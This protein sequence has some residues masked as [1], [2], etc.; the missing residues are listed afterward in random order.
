M[1]KKICVNCGEVIA[2]GSDYCEKCGYNPSLS[3]DTSEKIAPP[4]PERTLKNK[5]KIPGKGFGITSLVT[6]IIALFYG[7]YFVYGMSKIQLV[8][9]LRKLIFYMFFYIIDFAVIAIVFGIIARMKGYINNISK[10]SIG[11]GIIALCCV[12][13][14]VM[15]YFQYNGI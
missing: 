12:F 1:S 7:V 3:N 14:A 6:G 15:N 11:L 9:S 10:T 8:F 4:L 2:E 13:V 5:K